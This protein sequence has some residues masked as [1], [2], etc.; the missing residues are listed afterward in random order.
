MINTIHSF[1]IASAY[2]LTIAK[3][4]KSTV[5]K[6]LAFGDFSKVVV[7]LHV[8]ATEVFYAAKVLK[9]KLNA[10]TSHHVFLSCSTSEAVPV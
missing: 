10:L 2:L 4:N 6:H 8:R 3:Q 1:P 5:V 7:F 9:I